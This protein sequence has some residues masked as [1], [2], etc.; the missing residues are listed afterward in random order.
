MGFLESLGKFMAGLFPS[1]QKNWEENLTMEQIEDME[2]Q[3]CDMTEYRKKYEERKAAEEAREQEIR[4]KSLDVLD[5]DKLQPYLAK[6]RDPESEFV[7]D[8]I[9][10]NR[11]GSKN[12]KKVPEGDLIYAS[13]VQAHW[14]LLEPGEANDRNMYAAVFCFAM[15][16]KHMHDV[17]WLRDLAKKISA[18]KN[19]DN[20]PADNAK[21]IETLRDDQSMFCF[22]LGE[23]LAGDADAWCT[24]R[25]FDGR[26]MLPLGYMPATRILPMMLTEKPEHDHSGP[27]HFIPLKYYTK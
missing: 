2:R 21:F 23:S 7:K 10:L 14:A 26:K 5:M 11:I 22:K 3:G 24:T 8:M 9:E 6:P 19:S 27:M 20:V 18:M 4:Q 1:Q 25:G 17:E 13:L 16:E 12:A 15:D